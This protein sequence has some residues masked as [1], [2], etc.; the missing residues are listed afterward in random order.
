MIID[1]RTFIKTAGTLALAGVAQSM[2]VLNPLPEGQPRIAVFFD[3]SFPAVDGVAADKTVLQQSFGSWNVVYLNSGD[4]KKQ[5]SASAHDVLV[6]PYGSAFPKEA[7]SSIIKFLQAGG[8]WVNLGGAPFSVP[9]VRDG[10]GWRPEV[11]QT[12]YH[13]RLG[14]TQSFPVSGK[15]ISS[16]SVNEQ[17]TVP[18]S[19]L[20]EFSAEEVF[21]LYVRFTETVDFPN[22]GGSAGTRDAALQSLVFGLSK[23]KVKIAAPFIR[24]D[25]MQ[26]SFAGGCWVLA[27][28]RG[29]LSSDA[30]RFMVNQALHGSVALTVR[31]TFGSY[32]EGESPSFTIQCR[33]PG[34][35]AEKVVA[36]KCKIEV[37]D[38]RGK[39]ID[40]MSATLHGEGAVVSASVKMN[41]SLSPGLYH[42]DVQLPAKSASSDYVLSASTGFWIYDKRLL[43]GGTALTVD[44]NYLLRDGKP[45][46][47][48]GTTYMGSDVHR[49][50]LFEPN[51]HL[52]DREFAKMK[53]AG[54]NMVRTGIWTGWK[55]YMLDVGV[56]N[57]AA[58]RALDAF[59]LTA[60]KYDIPV[61][62]TFFAFLPE[63][64]GG[65][66]AYL[67]PRSVSA[68][69]EFI[70][71]FAQRYRGINDI[72]WD[73]INE[74]S[75]CNPG[76]LWSCRPNYDAFETEAWTAWLKERYPAPSEEEF[77]ARMQER[78]R[79]TADEALALPKLDEFNDVNIFGESQPIKIIDYR[80]FAQEMFRRWVREMTALI[81]SNGNLHQLV[82]V[83]QDEGGTN[84]SPSPHFFGDAVDFTCVHNWWLNDDLV[85][86]NVIMKSPGKPNLVEET[87]IMFYEK[88]DGAPWRTEEAAAEL[89]ERKLAVSIGAGGADFIE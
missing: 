43:E 71:A 8:S 54:I 44:G 1:R 2:P 27:N 82:T 24:I 52:W 48:T 5:L 12:E 64:W 40:A 37:V 22:E 45:F 31:S 77:L 36:G 16:Y 73:F 7:W 18:Q 55:N 78:Y 49:K 25:R 70:A 67:D 80:L 30:I 66:N 50:F 11:R 39:H 74:P 6:L 28:F 60:R 72:L 29:K 51:P 41:R 13:Q 34:G 58:F 46:I 35:N 15:K 87:G 65:V 86:D 85:W 33:K 53:S 76:Y 89:L 63:T 17:F 19:V 4:L 26:G 69:K 9:V 20:G 3:E 59:L 84:E 47:V 81:R 88:M 42:V 14:I 62:F 68:E 57:E 61:I 75:F 79:S 38:D 83:G 10:T 21:E 23:E 56:P 32:Y